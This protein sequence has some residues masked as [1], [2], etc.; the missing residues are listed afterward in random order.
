M[1]HY[2]QLKFVRNFSEYFVQDKNLN[3]LE[4]GSYNYNG[5][6]KNFFPNCKYIGVDIVEGPNVDLVYNGK[7]LNF[8]QNQFDISISCECFEH[9]PFW[10]KNFIDLISFTK[11]GGFVLITCATLG[12]PEHGTFRSDLDSSPG[13]MQKWNFYKNLSKKDFEKLKLNN[14]FSD[15][16]IWE[17]KMSRDLYFLGIKKG[18]VIKFEEI[19]KFS[20]YIIY[21]NSVVIKYNEKF[22]KKITRLL[23]YL[24]Q[25]YLSKIIP[26]KNFRNLW[27]FLKK[28]VS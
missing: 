2:Q 20:D 15:Y 26:D 25:N 24:I 8:K 21:K 6:I 1:A 3:I 18:T 11:P 23:K 12:R 28:L 7:D 4:L 5:T 14:Y 17:D 22:L 27:I 10:Q 13:S 9:N 19:E 16:G